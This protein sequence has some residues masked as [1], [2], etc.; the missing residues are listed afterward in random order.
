LVGTLIEKRGIALIP[1]TGK[2]RHAFVALDDVAEFL[3]KAALEPDAA[4]S[5]IENL[6]GPESLSYEEV[7]AIF[8]RVLARP[9]RVVRTPSAVY[10]VMADLLEPFSPAAGNLM[11]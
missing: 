11:A 7:V 9:V 5:V 8:A 4:P 6:G 10:R 2:N 1:G 3:A